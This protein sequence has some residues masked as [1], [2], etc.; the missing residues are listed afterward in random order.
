MMRYSVMEA[1]MMYMAPMAPP[2]L[3]N[4]HSWWF[5][6]RA[7]SFVEEGYVSVRLVTMWLMI[8]GMSSFGEA[9]MASWATACKNSGVKTYHLS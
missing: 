6:L 1:W 4:T 5:E 8:A 9:A 2:A 3:L 7:I